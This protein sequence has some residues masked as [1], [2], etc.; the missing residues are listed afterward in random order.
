[1]GHF[2][3]LLLTN[4]KCIHNSDVEGCCF[5]GRG[6]LHIRGTCLYGKLNYH[7]GKN[8]A[9]RE[10]PE[11]ALFPDVNFCEDPGQICAGA[12]SVPLR[13]ISGMYHWM[14]NVQKYNK[15]GFN[16][17]DEL[18]RYV[19]ENLVGT[20]FFDSTTNIHVLGCHDGSCTQRSLK[21]R[22]DRLRSFEKGELLS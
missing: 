6:S 3:I 12:N 2:F 16:Y 7:L 20:S 15:G 8:K 14:E 1:M 22:D 5:W 17:Q 4:V 10:G 19:N 18:V 21:D 13:W 11:N 9:D